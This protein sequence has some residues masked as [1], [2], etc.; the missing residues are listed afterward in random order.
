MLRLGISEINSARVGKKV[1]LELL[2]LNDKAKLIHLIGI[3]IV[4]LG[5]ECC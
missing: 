2:I 3:R 5:D 1:E 4:Q